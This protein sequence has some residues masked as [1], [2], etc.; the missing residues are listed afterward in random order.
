MKRTWI[1]LTFFWLVMYWLLA[2]QRHKDQQR[3]PSWAKCPGPW[4]DITRGDGFVVGAVCYVNNQ[5]ARVVW[6]TR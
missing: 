6:F 2:W 3:T 4:T 5:P 1:F